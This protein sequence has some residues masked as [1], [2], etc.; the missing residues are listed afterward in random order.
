MHDLATNQ[1]MNQEAVAAAVVD[2]VL[3]SIDIKDWLDDAADYS[4][5]GTDYVSVEV[6]SRDKSGNI[7]QTTDFRITP[8]QARAM[9]FA[10][11]GA[12]D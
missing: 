3:G 10:I 9:F 1:R 11:A 7:I 6:V 4:S 2:E 5:E 8:E 12:V